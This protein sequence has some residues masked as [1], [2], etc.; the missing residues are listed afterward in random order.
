MLLPSPIQTYF[1][2]N[3]TLDPD[4]MV[5]PFAEGAMVYDE[6]ARYDGKDAIRAWIDQSTVAVSAI[7]I[8]QA[9]VSRGNIH[10]VTAEVS[11]AFPASPV[12]L[13][14][15]FALDADRITE[16]EIK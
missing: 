11:G 5:A 2:A 7:A 6:N 8:P 1:D 3:T 14:F 15:R 12:S 16:L 9:I 4:A 10:S 13:T